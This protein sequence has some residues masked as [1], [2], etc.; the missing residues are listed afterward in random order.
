LNLWYNIYVKR[1][2]EK[3]E[4]SCV[5]KLGNK[6]EISC[7]LELPFLPKLEKIGSTDFW[8]PASCDVRLTSWKAGT[9]RKLELRRS[10]AQRL[11]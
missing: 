5:Y 7:K 4:I 2:G 3:L 11:R 8:L 10:L 6:L 1:K 9:L